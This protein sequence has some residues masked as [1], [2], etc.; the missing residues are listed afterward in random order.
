MTTNPSKETTMSDRHADTP[1]RI[2]LATD[3]SARSDRAL[4]R[5]VSVARQWDAEL[6]LAHIIEPAPDVTDPTFG[7]PSWRRGPDLDARTSRRIRDDLGAYSDTIRLVVE[8]GSPVER[9]G[10]IA[11]REGAE[12]IVTGVARAATLG[13]TLLGTTVQR[14][15]RTAKVP[16]LVVKRRATRDYRNILVPIDFSDASAAAVTK[17]AAL[18]P[19]A[20]LT[21]LH[22]Y[23]VP[24]ILSN[25]REAFA[26]ELRRAE[27]GEADAF[28][29]RCAPDAATRAR[30]DF[31]LEHGNPVRLAE[32]YVADRDPDLTVVASH[33]RSMLFELAIGSTATRMLECL[34]SDVL[35]VRGSRT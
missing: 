33:G 14:L 24:F 16:I 3:L 17:A 7:L 35:L 15:A 34:E 21:V 20:S 1:R 30:I 29:R 4:D 28:L 19:L 23:D 2:L 13:R 6:I 18:F 32:T 10:E 22:G 8:H 25:H 26:E 5:A 12:L 11:E 31:R 27:A 9:I